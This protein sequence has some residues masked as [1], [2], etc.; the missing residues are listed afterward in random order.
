MSE[1]PPELIWKKSSFSELKYFNLSKTKT[2]MMFSVCL[3]NIN[4]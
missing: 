2:S 1:D 4:S 3:S